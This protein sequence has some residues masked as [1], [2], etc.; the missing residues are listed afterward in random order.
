MDNKKCT[1]FIS[2]GG[3]GGHIYPAIAI[4][5]ELQKRGIENVYYVGNPKNP[6]YILAKDNKIN[7][8]PVNINAMPR[9]LSFSS[10]AWVIKLVL[11]ILKCLFYIIKH[12]PNLVFGTGGYVSAPI[13]F[14]ARFLN[15]PYALH[16][17]D[18]QPGV[19]TRC[20]A[21]GA[22][23]LT[24]PFEKVK[25]ILSA[26]NV[27]VTGNPIRKEFIEI[28]KNN[29]RKELGLEEKMTILV[30]GGSQGARSINNAI[31]PIIKKLVDN[32]DVFI[33]HQSG[34]KR[35]E[36]TI[37]LL[38]KEFPD[39]ENSK[40]YRLL[41]YIDDM[42]TLLNS[43]DIAISRSGS[44]SLSEIKASGVASILIPYPYSAGGHQKK[45]AEAMVEEGCSLM[46][47]DFDLTPEKLYE[48]LS[49]LIINHER[50][51]SMQKMAKETSMPNATQKIVEILLNFNEQ[52]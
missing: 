13:L 33:L 8:L 31:V 7:F 22:V 17:A 16:D 11:A 5:K 25:N 34:K 37:E 23:V 42:P 24:T 27:E 19:V 14:A 48:A 46:I 21:S 36:E 10:F 9:K 44:L 38:K 6:E 35:Y 40:N 20:F 39:Y 3:T 50:M 26:A 4:I 52:I 1:Y 32:F 41:P 30:M 12:K 49:D 29:A 47:E 18:A 45:N 28:N 51:S 43:A 15:I 2:G